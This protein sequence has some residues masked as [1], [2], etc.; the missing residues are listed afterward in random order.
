MFLS[1]TLILSAL[2]NRSFISPS[3]A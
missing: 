3:I 1:N 2:N